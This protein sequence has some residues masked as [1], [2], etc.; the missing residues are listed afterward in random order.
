ME[1]ET[2]GNP[3]ALINESNEVVNVVIWDG[4]T[5][6]WQP[7]TGLTAVAFD[8]ADVRI[9]L[10]YNSSGTGVGIESTNKWIDTPLTEEEIKAMNEEAK[11]SSSL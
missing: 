10:K 5:T 2:T 8:G 9:G 4:D 7:E 6:K 11:N 3:Y 1:L